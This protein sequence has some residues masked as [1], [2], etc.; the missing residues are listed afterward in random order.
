MQSSV[1]KVRAGRLCKRFFSF[2]TIF[3][4]GTP[5]PPKFV[6]LAPGEF[7][8]DEW[9]GFDNS[10]FIGTSSVFLEARVGMRNQ[11]VFGNLTG[12]NSSIFELTNV[13]FNVRL[14]EP[15]PEPST[16]LLLASGLAG[17][18]FFR[19]RRKARSIEPANIV[20]IHLDV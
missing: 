8:E 16:M 2:S 19:W 7:V 6:T 13:P 11:D 18:G 5:D 14:V 3:N 1:V 20:T 17:L 12:G 9:G 10:G 15:I 4:I